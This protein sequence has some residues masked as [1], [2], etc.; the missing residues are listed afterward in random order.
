MS[1]YI[2]PLN[3]EI[4]VINGLII[5]RKIVKTKIPKAVNN[6]FSNRFVIYDFNNL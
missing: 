1:F 3:S 4:C 5:D 6:A 2:V